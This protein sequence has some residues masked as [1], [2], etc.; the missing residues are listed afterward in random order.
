MRNGSPKFSVVIPTCGRESLLA[1]LRGLANQSYADFEVVAVDDGSPQPVASM[2]GIREIP[3]ELRI[4]R[5]ENAGPAAA[6][7][8]GAAEARGEFLAFTDDDC[9]PDPG[10]LAAL[11]RE[12]EAHPDALCGSLTYNGLG[13]CHWACTSQLIIDLVYA[14]FNRY[15]E[16]AY[17]LTSNNFACRRSLYLGM[18]GFDSSF[19]KA[20]AE[21]R[22]FCD[23]W[24]MTGRRIRLIEQR[25]LKHRH[26]QSL[27]KFLDIHYRYGR[28]AYLYQLKRKQRASGTM[29][30]DMGFHRSL[31]KML[32]SQ[33]SG[34]PWTVRLG[35]VAA[36]GLWQFVNAFGFFA[37]A[38]SARRQ[39]DV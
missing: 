13:D 39:K 34:L 31:L 20:G 37:I 6:R 2:A 27:R 36:L 9:I 30:E 17:F 14:H 12:L 35:R 21:D 10:W 25:L 5:Q 33:L 4:L 23:R 18:G 28:G 16:N 24:R 7:N 15:P 26:N 11:A 22:D 1:C 32:P 3:V 19:S 38:F 8:A 29:A